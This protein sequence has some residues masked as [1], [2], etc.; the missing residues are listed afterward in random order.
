MEVFIVFAVIIL[1]IGFVTKTVSKGNFKSDK[2]DIIEDAGK[3]SRDNY[4]MDR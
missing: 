1:F 2:K 4:F 3:Y